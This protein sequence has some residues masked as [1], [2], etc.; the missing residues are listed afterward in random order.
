M[1][2]NNSNPKRNI[3]NSR[4]LSGSSNYQQISITN[5]R[6]SHSSLVDDNN[7]E[8]RASSNSSNSTVQLTDDEDDVSVDLNK[9][10]ISFHLNNE[11]NPQTPVNEKRRWTPEENSIQ[12]AQ[13]DYVNEGSISQVTR[14]SPFKQ[15]RFFTG[16]TISSCKQHQK[17][18]QIVV[19]KQLST[20]Y[21]RHKSD[22]NQSLKTIISLRAALGNDII[23]KRPK[24]Y[25]QSLLSLKSDQMNHVRKQNTEQPYFPMNGY[26]SN[27]TS[28]TESTV[29]KISRKILKRSRAT[30][31][32]ANGEKEPTSPR[33]HL[34]PRS[35]GVANNSLKVTITPFSQQSQTKSPR[36]SNS[37]SIQQLPPAS[38]DNSSK[39]INRKQQK[40][41][42]RKNLDNLPSFDPNTRTMPES[43]S[44]QQLH[45][46]F[47]RTLAMNGSSRKQEIQANSSGLTQ[48]TTSPNRH[49]NSANTI[50]NSTNTL[51]IIPDNDMECDFKPTITT[52]NKNTAIPLVTTSDMQRESTTSSHNSSILDSTSSNSLTKTTD[53]CVVTSLKNI[54]ETTVTLMKQ[55]KN[56]LLVTSKKTF[57]ASNVNEQ[58]KIQ[59]SLSALN[60][61]TPTTVSPR[62]TSSI[63]PDLLQQFLHA[64][65][66]AAKNELNKQLKPSLSSDVNS[67]L[68]QALLKIS[69]NYN[70]LSPV[71]TTAKTLFDPK[72]VK[73]SSSTCP[74]DTVT[75]NPSNRQKEEHKQRPAG[76]ESHRV[77]EN[78]ISSG[79]IGLVPENTPPFRPV[80]TVSN[81]S[82]QTNICISTSSKQ[83]IS[84]ICLSPCQ[85]QSPS[86]S[87]T[88]TQVSDTSVSQGSPSI[89]KKQE[90]KPSSNQRKSLT[91]SHVQSIIHKSLKK[92]PT[93]L[94]ID[95]DPRRLAEDLFI[96]A[97]HLSQTRRKMKQ[98]SDILSLPVNSIILKHNN[99]IQHSTSISLPKVTTITSK[100]HLQHQQQNSS[101]K[102]L[103]QFGQ[104]EIETFYKSA[105]LPIERCDTKP[106]STDFNQ[107]PCLSSKLNPIKKI[108]V[109]EYCLKYFHN[110]EYSWQRH[111]TKCSWT[112][113]YGLKLYE[114]DKLT[115]YEVNGNSEHRGFCQNLCLLARLFIDSKNVDKYVDRFLFYILYEKEILPSRNSSPS[116]IPNLNNNQQQLCNYQMIGYF[117]K[118]KFSNKREHPNLS[119]LLVLPQHAK[120][121]YSKILIEFSYL[122]CQLENKT[123]LLCYRS[124][125]REKILQFIIEID[126]IEREISSNEVAKDDL[127]S[128]SMK[129]IRYWTGFLTK[130][131]LS[132]LQ[133]F[134]LIRVQDKTFC[135][136]KKHP[137]YVE[138]KRKQQQHLIRL[139]VIIKH[140]T[141]LKNEYEKKKSSVNKYELK[142]L[143]QTLT[144]TIYNLFHNYDWSFLIDYTCLHNI[145]QK[146][147]QT[148]KEKLL[149]KYVIDWNHFEEHE[150]ETNIKRENS[151]GGD[152]QMEK[153]DEIVI[154]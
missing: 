88:I 135:V 139:G 4:I 154:L 65:R 40:S 149:K 13:N 55:T 134:G 60:Q 2:R 77:P 97:K 112:H 103:L 44:P 36:I 68:R 50:A 45:S 66:S 23:Y 51:V 153:G 86:I 98:D 106:N 69:K 9:T 137:L 132:T 95:F 17:Q 35:S 111:L 70:T 99:Q 31:S 19:K 100:T 25:I 38:T 6:S 24:N 42:N 114:T 47:E 84:Q 59:S 15:S 48:M 18:K 118:L 105:Y 26:T 101:S 117:S 57:T 148:Y 133:Y 67:K 142:Q 78:V 8:R 120:Q 140:V 126:Y 119:C 92:Q 63:P 131:I 10:N 104:C 7:R 146:N 41:T 75:I 32:P 91:S 82:S 56:D 30:I 11:Q 123:S 145:D 113:P 52:A 87:S 141:A 102:R 73:T 28:E 138:Q 125:W 46:S 64:F 128:I 124:Y 150:N 127:N 22:T 151:V 80:T 27:N 5:G 115:L 49:V 53:Q 74:S 152:N 29:Q 21:I 16:Q 34:R 71:T 83:S 62:L 61:S 12:S 76:I 110:E 37:S 20:N 143:Q 94:T 129:D 72:C 54:D 144:T 89:A 79:I 130:D 93:A 3:N 107:Q 121:G 85:M 1:T 81:I 122:L 109:C 33:K 58:N 147:L 136:I 90:N 108:Y 14:V 116:V 43:Q 39:K 96:Q